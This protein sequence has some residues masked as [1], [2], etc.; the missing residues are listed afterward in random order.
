MKIEQQKIETAK[1]QGS[2][3]LIKVVTDA[4][5]DEINNDFSAE[6]MSQFNFEQH[7][8]LAYRFFVDEINEGGFIQL[9]QNGY[10]AYIFE[11]PFAKSLKL[12]G[13]KELSKIIY[14]AKEIY[15]THKTDLQKETTDE[16]FMA[17]YVDYE[18]FD[19]LEEQFFM[20]EEQQT[21]LIAHYVSTHLDKF[22]DA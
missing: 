16:E 8:L 14:K 20:I 5:L 9:I 21:D 18:P 12:F 22:I 17:M 13:A 19:D 15:D 1:S 2:F 7:T 6:K 3:Q 11:N 10:G 4:Y